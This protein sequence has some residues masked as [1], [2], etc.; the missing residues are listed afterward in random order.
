MESTYASTAGATSTSADGVWANVLGL[1]GPNRAGGCCSMGP[2]HQPPSG[3]QREAVAD[4]LTVAKLTSEIALLATLRQQLL[5]G[6]FGRLNG[7][8]PEAA[9]RVATSRSQRLLSSHAAEVFGLMGGSA[10]NLRREAQLLAQELE[11]LTAAVGRRE[12]QGLSIAA[13]HTR[14][15]L[16][17]SLPAGPRADGRLGVRVLPTCS[18]GLS[19]MHAPHRSSDRS[20]DASAESGPRVSSQGGKSDG[21]A[22]GPCFPEAGGSAGSLERSNGPAVCGDPPVELSADLR[23]GMS[24][25]CRELNDAC[26]GSDSDCRSPTLPATNNNR[27]AAERTEDCM[28]ALQTGS[29]SARDSDGE[30]RPAARLPAGRASSEERAQSCAAEQSRGAARGGCNGVSSGSSATGLALVVSAPAPAASELGCQSSRAGGASLGTTSGVLLELRPGWEAQGRCMRGEWVAGRGAE[31]EAGGMGGSSARRGVESGVGKGTGGVSARGGAENGAGRLGDGRGVE[32]GMRRSLVQRH[33]AGQEAAR[34][35]SY[36]SGS[37]YGKAGAAGGLT[38]SVRG[39]IPG[40]RPNIAGGAGGAQG[41]ARG[42]GRGVGGGGKASLRAPLSLSAADPQLQTGL[43]NRAAMH[44]QHRKGEA[45]GAAGVLRV[46]DELR[47]A[48]AGKLQQGGS[49]PPVGGRR[50]GVVRRMERGQYGAAAALPVAWG[51]TTTDVPAMADGVEL[52]LLRSQAPMPQPH[53][54]QMLDRSSGRVAQALSVTGDELASWQI[55]T[56]QPTM[57]ADAQASSPPACGG[58]PSFRYS[59]SSSNLESEGG[60]LQQLEG[61]RLPAGR[62]ALGAAQAW[63]G[64]EPASREAGVRRPPV[65]SF[66]TF[67]SW[68]KREASRQAAVEFAAQVRSELAEAVEQGGG[69]ASQG[70]AG[71]FLISRSPQEQLTEQHASLRVEPPPIAHAPTPLA[72]PPLA[73][74]PL[75]PPPL[76][77]AP[78]LLP[79]PSLEPTPGGPSRLDSPPVAP[80]PPPPPLLPAQPLPPRSLNATAEGVWVPA[81][82]AATPP[83]AASLPPPILLSV[84]PPPP[85]PIPPPPPPPPPPPL[86][87]QNSTGPPAPPCK[88]PPPPPGVPVLPPNGAARLK[89]LHWRKIGAAQLAPTSLWASFQQHELNTRHL[90]HLRHLFA[91]KQAREIAPRCSAGPL[92]SQGTGRRTEL[93]SAKRAQNIEICISGMLAAAAGADGLAQHV[94]TLNAMGALRCVGCRRGGVG[95]GA[96][97]KVYGWEVVTRK[98]EIRAPLSTHR[99]RA[100]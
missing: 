61:E 69:Y 44:A 24:R 26:G 1:R 56:A 16:P 14:A 92:S 41:P 77:P 40:I 15:V 95:T 71:R 74:P 65:H 53:G 46:G 30:D 6:H 63:R 39:G 94:L 72:P 66:A 7:S 5:G 58:L 76:A 75:G 22:P 62:G 33:K 11:A 49:A 84:P 31:N 23:D 81:A 12:H 68:G 13:S 54:A 20:A 52:N 37:A 86:K 64:G 80:P 36:G 51:E 96:N 93:L 83:S 29:Q 3:R 70:A 18:A 38:G 32:S 45:P 28:T 59:M 85:P 99:S 4:R 73:P 2:M 57:L 82:G 8:T 88:P 78:P 27:S 55:R 50:G 98:G 90:A 97:C 10:V 43:S 47:M 48:H 91:Y 79:R 21:R 35:R 17:P 89:P 87:V 67:G 19:H 9:V 25:A 42:A 34:R 60:G 100:S